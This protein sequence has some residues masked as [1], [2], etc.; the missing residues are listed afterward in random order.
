MK[1]NFWGKTT[2]EKMKKINRKRALLQEK[3][4]E[5]MS[6]FRETV[7]ADI[8][9]QEKEK[10]YAMWKSV[11]PMLVE[12]YWENRKIQTKKEIV[13]PEVNAKI[14]VYGNVLRLMGIWSQT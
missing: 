1:W 8:D 2:K 14:E 10:C 4:D 11:G 12:G 9:R 6:E 3:F 13:P 5:E 7:A